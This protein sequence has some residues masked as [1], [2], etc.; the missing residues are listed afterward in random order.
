MFKHLDG[1]YAK[2][3]DTNRIL[4]LVADHCIA[5]EKLGRRATMDS[6]MA[7]PG[8]SLPV[9]GDYRFTLNTTADFNAV[10]VYNGQASFI[11]WLAVIRYNQ[12]VV[13]GVETFVDHVQAAQGLESVAA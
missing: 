9:K 7:L 6:I 3:V 12:V 13:R 5:Q 4:T 10:M 8:F 2:S 11:D 1:D